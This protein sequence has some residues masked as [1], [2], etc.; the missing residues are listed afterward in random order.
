MTTSK[1][2]L[3]VKDLKASC[4]GKEILKGINLKIKRGEILAIFGPNGSGKTALLNTILGINGFKISNGKILFQNRDIG[5]LSTDQ[6]VRKGIALMFQ[7]PAKISGVKLLD[8]LKFLETDKQVL[9]KKIQALNMKKLINREINNNFSGGELKRSELLQV[10]LQKANL[11]LLD[12]PDSGVDLEN[13]KLIGKELNLLTKGKRK[14]ALIITHTGNI[15]DYLKADRACVLID[16][17]ICC[18]D[19]PEVILETIKKYG[20]EKCLSCKK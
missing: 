8:L 19:K 11:Y 2:I 17:E 7:K 16:G 10:I 9:N 12:E 1:N 3:E 15:L 4:G 6:K 5:H 18:E 20:Y 13:I 14:S